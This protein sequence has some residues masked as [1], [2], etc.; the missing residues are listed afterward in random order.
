MVSRKILPTFFLLIVCTGAMA[1]PLASP[2]SALRLGEQLYVSNMGERPAPT[3]KDGDGFISRHSVNGEVIERRFLP[4]SGSLD[5]PKGLAHLDGTLFVADIDRILGFS[6]ESR[7]QVFELSLQEAGARSLNDIAVVDRRLLVSDT[8][9]GWMFEIDPASG[10]SRVLVKGAAGANG[11]V[12]DAPNRRLYVAGYGERGRLGYVDL[13][14]RWPRYRALS[15]AGKLDGIGML[16]GWLIVSDWSGEQ[17][18]QLHAYQP[19]RGAAVRNLLP[20]PVDGPADFEL[21]AGSGQLW[22]PVMKEN[23]L[24]IETISLP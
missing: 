2:E 20:E 17:G 4:V 1:Q 10:K 13:D 9:R 8:Q 21:D 22:L 23:R 15:F 6:L 3:Q 16:D 18:G 19:R 11:L 12:Y 14:T 5:A 7:E 24:L